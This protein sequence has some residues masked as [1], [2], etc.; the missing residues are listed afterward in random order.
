MTQA[1]TGVVIHLGI[2]SLRSFRSL[3]ATTH[4]L[5]HIIPL[6]AIPRPMPSPPTLVAPIRRSHRSFILLS[7][8]LGIDVPARP[9][10]SHASTSSPLQI[11]LCSSLPSACLLGNLVPVSS[12]TVR[13]RASI[14]DV[15]NA[16]SRSGRNGDRALTSTSSTGTWQSAGK[17]DNL[18]EEG[19]DGRWA[20][21]LV[22]WNQHCTVV[23]QVWNGFREDRDEEV[24]WNKRQAGG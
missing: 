18:E 5:H 6:D 13:T 9:S 7:H 16:S 17:L 8:P 24:V 1:Q 10:Q 23:K 11:P 2:K 4:S 14:V 12:R 19:E 22:D 20:N 15:R 3:T 21:F